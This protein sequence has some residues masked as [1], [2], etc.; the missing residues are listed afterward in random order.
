M[1]SN[2]FFYIIY[3]FLLLIVNKKQDKKWVK[4]AHFDVNFILLRKKVPNL[5]VPG[6]A[7]RKNGSGRESGES[8]SSLYLFIL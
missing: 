2:D 7:V 8:V 1:K 5:S 3:G 4:N 6:L